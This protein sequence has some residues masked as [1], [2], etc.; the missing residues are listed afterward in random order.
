MTFNINCDIFYRGNVSRIYKVD[1][2]AL[3]E[4]VRFIH[5]SLFC[6]MSFQNELSQSKQ[7]IKQI[8]IIARM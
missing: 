4:C 5:V 3:P 6:I 7:D 1:T 2:T 8:M